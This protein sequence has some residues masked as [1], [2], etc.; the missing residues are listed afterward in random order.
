M[1]KI[2]TL[3]SGFGG[4]DIGAQAA[5][6]E[7]AWGL[8]YDA[9]IAGV[10]ETNGFSATVANILEVDPR[11]FAVV[12]VLHASPPCPSFSTAK[13]GRKETENDV[14]MARAVA[15]FIE[16][17][18]PKVFTLENVYGYR[19][20]QGFAAILAALDSLGYMY[21]YAHINAADFGVPQTRRR[22]W[23]RAVRG[24][25]VPTLPPAEKWVGWYE[26]IEDLIPGLPG[27]QFAPW[28]ERQMPK[29]C[30]SLMKTGAASFLGYNGNAVA[31]EENT[32]SF[33]VTANQNQATQIRGFIV[34]DQNNGSPN[35][36]GERGLTIRDDGNPMF[37]VSATQTKRSV[38]AWLS[39]GRVVAMTPR[40]LARFQS[41]PDWYVLPERNVL[42]CKGIGNA[43]PPLLYQKLIAQ[44]VGYVL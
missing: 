34:D 41:F 19:K 38:R 6:I 14:A 21:S 2:G 30:K 5:G 12:N 32:P 31:V 28:Q 29:W 3:F 23:L 1:L 33:T 24:A 20:A 4:V 25:L 44:F 27:S 42:A 8:E 39:Q 15:G 9:D 36:D 43:V 11:D 7:H 37:T 40:C 18:Q 35:S 22:L 16:E 13:V 10:A 26:A 17:L